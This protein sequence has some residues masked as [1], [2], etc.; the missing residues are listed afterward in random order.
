MKIQDFDILLP[1][2]NSADILRAIGEYMSKVSGF[3]LGLNEFKIPANRITG[4]DGAVQIP[5]TIS[6]NEKS[7]VMVIRDVQAASESLFNK[8]EKIRNLVSS[9]E[10]DK[11]TDMVMLDKQFISRLSKLVDQAES[12]FTR[13]INA[14][15]A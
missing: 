11:D 15:S 12:D 2:T 7:V 6:L 4:Q 3:D 8:L 5:R 1:N 13:I 14:Q 10:V 9:L